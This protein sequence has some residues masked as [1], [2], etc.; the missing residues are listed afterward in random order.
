[1]NPKQP[2]STNRLDEVERPYDHLMESLARQTH[3]KWCND[4]RQN[5]WRFGQ[6]HNETHKTSPFLLPYD[7]LPDN[8][9][10]Q[11]LSG[12][13]DTLATI[14]EEGYSILKAEN[15]TGFAP[16]L[17]TLEKD[18]ESGK[19]ST[20]DAK[21]LP[22]RNRNP[23]LWRK[24]PSLYLQAGKGML[25]A[26]EPLLAY[27][28]LSEGVE[29]MGGPPMVPELEGEARSLLISLLQQ[30]ALSL[31]QSGASGEA[32]T[33]LRS[34]RDAG[35]SDS[36]TL[37]ILGRTWKDMA[38]ETGDAGLRE[39]YLEQAFTCYHKTYATDY[40]MRRY[41]SAYYT[42]I[43]AATVSLLA[44]DTAES[45]KIAGQVRSICENILRE[46][47]IRNEDVSFWLYASLGEA[48]LLQ[49]D[50]AGAEEFYTLAAQGC[51][52]DIRA[53][54]SMRKQARYILHAS[55]KNSK[56]LD[57]CFPVPSV[58]LFSGHIIDYPGRRR[59]RFPPANEEMVRRH[60][61]HWLDEQNGQIGFS[62]AACGSDILFLEEMLKRGGEIN[63]VLPFD[64]EAFIRT[65]VDVTG[66]GNWVE[67]FEKILDQVNEIKILSQYN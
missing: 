47:K 45:R 4:R 43:N 55:G 16:E 13:G 58:V 62:S 27:D 42:G 36:E 9:K 31:A 28:I 18:L 3:D 64:R 57:R 66:G 22:W 38:M 65:S 20:I 60:I 8:K 67:R 63:V 30:Q 26:G 39:K 2:F 35:V 56:A 11:L 1:M 5:G 52:G 33:I 14:I 15:E 49:G 46:K 12:A 24:H 51:A 6:R 23:Q 7:D 29:T 32:N 44:G 53:L 37:G 34:L 40:R 50:R 10:Q 48:S 41:E 21:L 59:N 61:A 19:A 54:G 17:T 25:S